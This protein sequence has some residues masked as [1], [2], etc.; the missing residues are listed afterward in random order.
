[1]AAMDGIHASVAGVGALFLKDA[2]LATTAAA[3]GGVDLLQR[4]YEI[5]LDRLGLLSR[6]EAQ[7]AGLKARDAAEAF[8]LQQAMTHRTHPCTSGPT[9]RCQ[10]SRKPPAS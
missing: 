1:M 7:I 10:R 4:A 3:G 8:E 6:L 2:A 9:T 5:R